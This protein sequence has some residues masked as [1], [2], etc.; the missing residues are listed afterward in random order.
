MN[1]IVGAGLAGLA[2]ATEM[3]RA[4]K[5]FLLLEAGDRVGGRL[6]T[7]VRDGFT[8]DHGF[9]VILSS[10]DAVGKIAYIPALEPRYFDSGALLAYGGQLSRI[11]NPL[12]HPGSVMESILSPAFS[13]RDKIL[14]G[15]LGGRVLLQSDAALL[16]RCG[17]TSDISTHDWLENFQLMRLKRQ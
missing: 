17:H 2:C 1:V 15:L 10:Y 9:Q 11:A 8:L 4:G 16:A 12:R 6:R 13:I 5:P 7:G 14:L 3:H